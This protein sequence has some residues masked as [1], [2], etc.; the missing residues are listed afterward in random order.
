[1]S[2]GVTDRQQEDGVQRERRQQYR[3][4]FDNNLLPMLAYDR[5]TLRI[6]AVNEAAIR[7]YGY[8]REEFLSMTIKDIR[9]PEDIPFLLEV[10]RR[11]PRLAQGT[12]E[13]GRN[14]HRCRSLWPAGVV[15]R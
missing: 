9:P 5:E 3:S 11:D 15:A 12:S 10:L 6:G 2:N 7:H 1:M 8:S 13:E 4:W 14:G